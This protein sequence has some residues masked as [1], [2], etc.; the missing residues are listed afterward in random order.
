[1]YKLYNISYLYNFYKN[2]MQLL[3][4]YLHMKSFTTL[5]IVTG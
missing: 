3:H 1:M 4:L 5:G 2:E